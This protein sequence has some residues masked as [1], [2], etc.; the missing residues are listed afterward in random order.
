M[1]VVSA[2]LYRQHST[3]I[4][5][6]TLKDLSKL[7]RDLSKVIIVD[8]IAEN[9][10][11]HKTNGLLISSWFDDPND[12]ALQSLSLFLKEIV[13]RQLPDV[14]VVIDQMVKK[15]GTPNTAQC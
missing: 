8:N 13:R 7:G 2:R 1:N 11:A 10:S 5:N 14:R 4:G 9:Y 3:K 6:E 15:M 12:T